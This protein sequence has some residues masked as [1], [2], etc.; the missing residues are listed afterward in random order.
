MYHLLFFS[1][2]PAALAIWR[3]VTR[4]DAR[5]QRGLRFD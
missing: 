2:N 1:K 5:G 4:I 3:G